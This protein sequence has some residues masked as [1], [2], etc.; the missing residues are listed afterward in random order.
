MVVRKGRRPAAKAAPVKPTRDV[1]VYAEKEPTEYHKVFARWIVNEVG[2]DP[3][4]AASKRQAF[5]MGVSIATAARPAFMESDF[6]EE[7][8]A[9]AGVAKRGPKPRVAEEEAEEAP[10]VRK[11]RKAAPEPEPEDE[12]DDEFDEDEGEED[13]EFDEDEDDADED[14]EDEDEDDEEDEPEPPARTRRQPAKKA[15]ATRKA[16]PPAKRT[17]AKKAAPTKTVRRAAKPAAEDDDFIF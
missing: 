9:K 6:I 5:L 7:W 4:Q 2:Y 3:N 13:D 17:A 10:L 16:A 8:R 11:T 15:V 1:T 14:D 12:D